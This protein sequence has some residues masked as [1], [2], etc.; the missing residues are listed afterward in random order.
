MQKA[1]VAPDLMHYSERF[2]NVY[3]QNSLFELGLQE[4]MQ[5]F[6]AAK[7]PLSQS[8]HYYKPI[9]GD[10]DWFLKLGLRTAR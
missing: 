7:W 6:V 4:Q 2:S 8:E 9:P 3:S 10:S 1:G 5:A